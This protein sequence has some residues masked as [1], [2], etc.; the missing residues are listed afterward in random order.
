VQP[1]K[2]YFIEGAAKMIHPRDPWHC[3]AGTVFKSGRAGSMIE[4]A[5]LAFPSFAVN[6]RDLAECFGLELCRV[7]VDECLIPA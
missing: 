6:I 5:R 3:P 7:A 1:Y 2:G 4:V